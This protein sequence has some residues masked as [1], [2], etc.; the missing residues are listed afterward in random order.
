MFSL[1]SEEEDEESE[2]EEEEEDATAQQHM[3]YARPV[4]KKPAPLHLHLQKHPPPPHHHHHH[5]HPQKASSAAA[6]PPVLVAGTG[7]A[8]PMLVTTLPASPSRKL[9]KNELAYY[10]YLFVLGGQV[11]LLCV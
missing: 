6:S 10:R 11:Y 3:Y 9:D 8:G 2:E 4:S 7:P 1:L 5:P